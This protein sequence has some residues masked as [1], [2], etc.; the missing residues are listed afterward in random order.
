MAG[1]RIIGIDLSTGTPYSAPAPPTTLLDFR[2]AAGLGVTSDAYTADGSPA[3]GQDWPF[4]VDADA[5]NAS[6]GA[7]KWELRLIHAGKVDAG[8]GS[9]RLRN[10][11]GAATM[12][13]EETIVATSITAAAGAAVQSNLPSSGAVRCR[14]QAKVTTGNT[15]TIETLRVEA[16]QRT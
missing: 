16:R 11:G 14:V 5:L 1:R 3:D 6:Y 2:S 4:V 8:T 9:L 13:S 10:V 15:F 12:G 7:E